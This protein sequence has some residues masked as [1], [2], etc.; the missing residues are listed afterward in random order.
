MRGAFVSI[1]TRAF[2]QENSQDE[3][4]RL[5]PLLDMLQHSSDP[6]IRHGLELADEGAGTPER[7]VVRARR[8]L[9]AGEELLNSYDDGEYTADKFLSRF[10]FVPGKSVG[11]FVGSLKT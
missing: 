8:P 11:E 6:N 7:V 1:L 2:T 10:G 3:E 5:V 9:L 4:N